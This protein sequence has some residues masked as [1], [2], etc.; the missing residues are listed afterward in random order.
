MGTKGTT[1][2]KL[3][4]Q[5]PST[6]D[7]D[8]CGEEFDTDGISRTKE[9]ADGAEWI[10][11]TCPHCGENTWYFLKECYPGSYEDSFGNAGETNAAAHD[12]G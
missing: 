1:T 11:A 4:D 2:M 5:L 6:L 3:N 12:L 10:V 9:T 8:E 7:C